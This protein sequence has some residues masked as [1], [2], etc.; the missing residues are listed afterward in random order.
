MK[1]IIM[2][3]L[4]TL[5]TGCSSDGVTWSSPQV[6][7]DDRSQSERYRDCISNTKNSEKREAR[8]RCHRRSTY[9]DPDYKSVSFPI[10]F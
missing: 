2:M 9:P 3:V 5:L 6:N 10:S 1:T 4:F 7:G 8:A